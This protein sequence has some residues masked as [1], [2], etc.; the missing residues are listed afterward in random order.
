MRKKVV[1][2]AAGACI[3]LAAVSLTAHYAGAAETSSSA[4]STIYEGVKVGPVEIGNMS[5]EEAKQAVYDYIEELLDKKI[6]LTM[7]EKQLE[8]SAEELGLSWAN[9]EILEE[10]LALGKSGNIIR[11]YKV[12]K[13]ISNQEQLFEMKF[14]TDTA[15][16]RAFLEENRE[17]LEEKA[18]D[19]SLEKTETGFLVKEETVGRTVEIEASAEQINNFF[20][21]WNHETGTLELAATVLMP[22]VTKEQCEKIQPEPM[23][24][25]TTSYSSS[26]SSRCANI[27]VA[28]QKINGT[29]LMP[30]EQFSCLEHMVPF[31]AE[32][33]YF[34]AGSYLNGMLVDSYGGG[35]CQ[36]STTLYNAVLLA[37]LDVIQRNNHGLTVGYVQLSS[38][39]AIAESSGMDL[40]F[41]NSTNAPVYIEG[42]TE[43]KKVTFQI[44]GYD[45]RPENRKIEYK[46]TITEVIQPPEDVITEDLTLA[47]GQKKVTQSS[48]TGYRAV[49]YKY[50]YVDGVQTDKIKVNSSYY[51]PAPNYISYNPTGVEEGDA[52]PGAEGGTPTD[53]PADIPAENP[54][55]VPTD[56]PSDIPSDILVE[57]SAAAET[58]SPDMIP[59]GAGIPVDAPGSL[60][61]MP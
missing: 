43:N 50:V 30:G 21:G 12:K 55:E 29:I 20:A 47:P 22:T 44:Y 40:I 7:G 3:C 57:T 25:F 59:E 5:K 27:D 39:A 18:L 32:N 35:V 23:A 46:N 16:V 41:S 38:D 9:E 13:D 4:A 58:I 15:K 17:K 34:P 26:G 14:A 6:T 45:E 37:E 2:I 1:G 52:V 53:V 19:A 61:E 36:V 33:G 28:V 11:R 48:H 24:S 56:K 54:T 49:L 8:A 42:Y 31:N 51:A 60:P 10:A